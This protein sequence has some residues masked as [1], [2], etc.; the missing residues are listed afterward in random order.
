MTFPSPEGTPSNVALAQVFVAGGLSNESLHLL[1]HLETLLNKMI[2]K[3][4]WSIKKEFTSVLKSFPV[5]LS[6]TLCTM[7]RAS[8]LSASG[9]TD[10]P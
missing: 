6:L 5:S 1:T 4:Q 8:L 3:E 9:S 7:S 2:I 10:S